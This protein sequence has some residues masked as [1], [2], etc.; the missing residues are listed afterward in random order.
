MLPL[1]SVPPLMVCRRKKKGKGKKKKKRRSPH[2]F[3]FPLYYYLFLGIFFIL[4]G[5]TGH[6]IGHLEFLEECGDPATN[7]AFGTTEEN[8]KSAI[9]GETH[10]IP[11]FPFIFLSTFVFPPISFSL[12]SPSLS[13]PLSEKEYTDMY[14]GMARTAREEGFD[15]VADWFEQLAMA[16]KSHAGRFQVFFS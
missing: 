1:S 15:D 12:F 8:L 3:S 5:E 13:P 2:S 14:P 11:L 16:E 7:M 6:A 9:A 4:I 10:V